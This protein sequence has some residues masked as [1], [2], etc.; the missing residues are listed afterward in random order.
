MIEVTHHAK[1]VTRFFEERLGAKLNNPQWSWGAIDPVFNRVFL[2]VWA[3]N[4]IEDK[5][6]VKFEVYWKQ[7]RSK[8]PGYPQRLKHLEAIK[9]GALGIGILC[10]AFDSKTFPRKIKTFDD[11][12]LLLLGKLSED[13]DCKYAHIVRRFPISELQ[14]LDNSLQNSAIDDIPVAPIGSEVPGKAPT[15]GSRY[16]RDDK[17]RQFIIEQA[18]GVCEYCGELGFLLPDG[19]HYLEAHHIIALAK[20]GPDTID[21]VIALCPSDHREA[22]YGERKVKLE[23][24]M[25]EIIKRRKNL[26]QSV[27]R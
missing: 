18:K 17:V 14:K 10:E 21:N 15:V 27:S 16:Q 11:E 13:D 20:Q 23:N 9:N 19:N 2:R 5:T 22:H 7:T 12:Q 3:D 6:G 26:H 24:E 25:I 1:G 4:Q 8:S